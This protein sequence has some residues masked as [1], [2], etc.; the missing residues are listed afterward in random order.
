LWDDQI[1]PQLARH[2][3]ITVSGDVLAQ[4]IR[5]DAPMDILK[6]HYPDTYNQIESFAKSFEGKDYSLEQANAR[7]SHFNKETSGLQKASDVDKAVL[8]T[9]RPTIGAELSVADALREEIYNA[10]SD[11][12]EKDVRLARKTYGA[13]T[14]MQRSAERGIVPSEAPL[15]GKGFYNQGPFGA[16]VKGWAILH[17][18]EG[19]PLGAAVGGGAALAKSISMARDAT[20]TKIRRATERLANSS[21]KGLDLNT[22][23]PPPTS[24]P[25]TPIVPPT[26]Q[27]PPMLPQQASPTNYAN[28]VRTGTPP[29]MNVNQIPNPSPA[30]LAPTGVPEAPPEAPTTTG[31]TANVKTTPPPES[32]FAM[33]VPKT[34]DFI[35]LEDLKPED[36]SAV[37]HVI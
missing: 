3:D 26:G 2:P 28:N 10:L 30:S 17:G 1:V 35:G 16:A 6:E 9:A 7:L 29:P 20:G 22:G 18:L 19:D 23:A 25:P 4:K 27:A 8:K 14:D 37:N 34:N 24:A 11:V 15:T 12:G 36:L 32:G 13:L 33:R 31:I 5:G 21:L